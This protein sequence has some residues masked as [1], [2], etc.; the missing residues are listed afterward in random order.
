[1]AEVIFQFGTPVLDRK[2][3][4]CSVQVCGRPNEDGLWDGWIEFTPVGGG[5]VL[6]TQRETTQPNRVDLEYWA[7]GLT[8]VYLE[9][10][11]Q[12]AEEPPRVRPSAVPSEPAYE[13]PRPTWES[14]APPAEARP[15]RA[16]LDPFAAYLQGEQV[17]REEL[18]A[19]A[20]GHLRNI[21]QTYALAEASSAE[22]ARISR[23]VLIDLIV[24]GVRKGRRGP[25]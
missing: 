23:P 15:R 18:S 4:P 14:A 12:R 19:L 22:L 11:L 1:M 25:R 13:G 5:E 3:Q 7:S 16:V 17:L 9:G 8:P 24:S 2:G 21:I 10:A 6:R 20:D